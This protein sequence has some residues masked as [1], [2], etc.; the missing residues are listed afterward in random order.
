MDEELFS[1]KEESFLLVDLKI[2]IPQE[3]YVAYQRCSW[4][5]VHETGRKTLDVMQEMVRDFLM[6]HGC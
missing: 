5:I 2:Q 1:E 6:K 4:M 3:L